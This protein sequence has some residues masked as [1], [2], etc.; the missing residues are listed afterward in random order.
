MDPERCKNCSL[1]AKG[2]QGFFGVR[3][4]HTSAVSRRSPK[5]ANMDSCLN[6]EFIKIF[7]EV[8]VALQGVMENELS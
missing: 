8:A 1:Q 3:A 4:N 6:W 2:C 5:T 7:H